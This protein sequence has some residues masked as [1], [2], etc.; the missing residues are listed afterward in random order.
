MGAMVC[1]RNVGTRLPG[2][3]QAAHGYSN[4]RLHLISKGEEPASLPMVFTKHHIAWSWGNLHSLTI[5]RTAHFGMYHHT[6]AGW[7]KGPM[8]GKQSKEHAPMTTHYITKVVKHSDTSCCN[9]LTECQHWMSPKSATVR[10]LAMIYNKVRSQR[11]KM[12]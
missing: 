2:V 12:K 4:H 9:Q 7:Y 8:H 11:N 5:V 6:C 1:A 3:G 10:I